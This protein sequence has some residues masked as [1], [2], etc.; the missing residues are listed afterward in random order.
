MKIKTTLLDKRHTG[1][2]YFSYLAVP[3]W[4]PNDTS[5]DKVDAIRQMRQWCWETFGPS[6]EYKEYAVLAGNGRAVNQRWCWISESF[7][8]EPRILIKNEEDYTWFVLRWS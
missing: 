1:N 4:Q 5:I 8:N 3:L 2:R 7:N 6:C